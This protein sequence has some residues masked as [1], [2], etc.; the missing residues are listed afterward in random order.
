MN[1]QCTQHCTCVL[2]PQPVSNYPP[3]NFCISMNCEGGEGKSE[4]AKLTSN[5]FCTQLPTQKNASRFQNKGISWPK[6][7]SQLDSVPWKSTW[8]STMEWPCVSTFA[9]HQVQEG[10]QD[11]TYSWY[12]FTERGWKT[13]RGLTGTAIPL[14]TPCPFP[15]RSVMLCHY[16][17]KWLLVLTCID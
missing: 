15:I 14:H 8:R 5:Q 6:W 2:R 7:T 16:G 11:V 17:K 10:R 9:L 4:V 3:T 12:R 13:Q 1:N